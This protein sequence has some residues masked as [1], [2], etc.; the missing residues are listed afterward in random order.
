MKI[1]TKLFTEMNKLTTIGL[2]VILMTAI[3]SC[4]QEDPDIN[5]AS[6]DDASK[7]AAPTNTNNRAHH[8]N[9]YAGQNIPVGRVS[10]SNDVNNIYVKFEVSD[11]WSLRGSHLYVSGGSFDLSQFPVNKR[12]NPAVNSFP[13]RQNH[14]NQTQFLYTIPRANVPEECMVI[15]AHANVTNGLQVKRAW[16][17]G[18][19][20]SK[21][22][23][24]KYSVYCR[25]MYNV[26][27]VETFTPNQ[28]NIMDMANLGQNAADVNNNMTTY[29]LSRGINKLVLNSNFTSLIENIAISN[30][31]SNLD[32]M[33]PLNQFFIDYPSYKV[34]FDSELQSEGINATYDQLKNTITRNG[35]TY[36]PIILV[37]NATSMNR[38]YLPILSSNTETSQCDDC[39]IA[40][41]YDQ[42]GTA[43]EIVLDE[44]TAMA[45]DIPLFFLDYRTVSGP[46]GPLS[47]VRSLP[48]SGFVIDK[49][50]KSNFART[51]GYRSRMATGMK[52]MIN[53]TLE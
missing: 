38:N 20:F 10:I 7:R 36:E 51:N 28:E 18:R 13:Y 35:Y 37:R 24:A 49:S 30:G 1:L 32:Y 50:S 48:K 27:S 22:S 9:L 17:E 40:W 11:G 5:I 39:I 44:A 19:E 16:A 3:V 33:V 21:G 47:L 46:N 41:Q 15:T 12:G 52:L 4:M 29:K 2:L 45:S 8:L 26:A 31:N 23:N 34:S 43:H 14:A 42:F 6:V 53:Q 25:E